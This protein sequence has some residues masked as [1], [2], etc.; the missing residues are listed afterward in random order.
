MRWELRLRAVRV[1]SKIAP[2]RIRFKAVFIL[3]LTIVEFAAC[4]YGAVKHR[5]IAYQALP[6]ILHLS[7]LPFAR[8]ARER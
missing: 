1:I 4:N 3:A 6:Q 7:H 5:A 2:I 8:G